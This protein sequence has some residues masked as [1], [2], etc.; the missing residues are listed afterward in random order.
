M[1]TTNDQPP[2]VSPEV[3][4]HLASN[5]KLSEDLLTVLH[6]ESAALKAMDTQSLFSVSRKKDSLLTKIQYLDNALRQAMGNTPER[7]ASGMSAEESRIIGQY[8]SKINLTRQEI[9]IKNL[10]NKRFTEDTLGYLSD[11]IGLFTRPAQ[12]ENTYRLPSRPRAR[13]SDLPSFI[14]CKA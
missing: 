13:K 5:L 12:E 8:K 9:Q 1:I 6:E 10:F 4:D 14:S 3:F 11:A 7:A 2:S